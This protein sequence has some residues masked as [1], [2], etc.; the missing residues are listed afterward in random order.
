MPIVNFEVNKEEILRRLANKVEALS[1]VYAPAGWCNDYLADCC[2]DCDQC[3]Q[4]GT[5]CC[6][7]ETS[8]CSLD[9]TNLNLSYITT[10]YADAISSW[11]TANGISYV[12]PYNEC[13]LYS[14]WYELDDPY[15]KSEH[16]GYDVALISRN[17]WATCSENN[18]TW[19]IDIRFYLQNVSDPTDEGEIWFYDVDPPGISGDCCGATNECIEMVAEQVQIQ[20]NFTAGTYASG[21]DAT[22]VINDNY[23]CL[24]NADPRVCQRMEEIQTNC[25]GQCPWCDGLSCTYCNTTPDSY[26]I[27]LDGIN[28]CTSIVDPDGHCWDI[29]ALTL[30]ATHCLT[31]CSEVLP[32]FWEKTE[33]LVDPL[34]R[35]E[36]DDG[37]CSGASDNVD[38]ILRI[39]LQ[40]VDNTTFRLTVILVAAGPVYFYN[41]IVFDGSVTVGDKECDQPFLVDNTYET[42]RCNATLSFQ[43]D[44]P[45]CSN[46]YDSAENIY[47]IGYNG[48]ISVSACCVL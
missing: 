46:D 29:S 14:K 34:I 5:A 11:I 47:N 6:F 40:K 12:I 19:H 2:C 33:N 10:E 20:S 18:I 9:I 48:N 44:I 7:D 24:N 8:T 13:A 17:V 21:C 23:C 41:F 1:T 43:E 38:G 4:C 22:I 15:D 31:Q 32:C 36:A 3:C 37:S 16:E 28:L 42:D 26:H 35:Y 30:D 27:V 39:T 25:D 45:G